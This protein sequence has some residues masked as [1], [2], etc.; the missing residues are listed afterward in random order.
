MLG[1]YLGYL[2][3]LI[4]FLAFLKLRSQN[5]YFMGEPHV[6]ENGNQQARKPPMAS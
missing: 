4:L 1:A 2:L 3:L 5:W 6:D